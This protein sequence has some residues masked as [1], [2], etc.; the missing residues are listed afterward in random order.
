MDKKG[1]I[2]NS[3]GHIGFKKLCTN[4]SDY[5]TSPHG[6]ITSLYTLGN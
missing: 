3:K 4:G 5:Y 6:P 1:E 2:L